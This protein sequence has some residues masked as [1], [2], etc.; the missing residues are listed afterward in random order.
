MTRQIGN[1]LS[2][3]PWSTN[4]NLSTQNP[5][6]D[7]WSSWSSDQLVTASSWVGI[8]GDSFRA[9]FSFVV[10]QVSA[11]NAT[12]LFEI[13]MDTSGGTSYTSIAKLL[14]GGKLGYGGSLCVPQYIPLDLAIPTERRYRGALLDGNTWRA[15]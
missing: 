14:V 1:G 12:C 4:A 15:R 5:G 8:L 3:E 13:G 11:E 6:N 10:G 9:T 2:I 7:A